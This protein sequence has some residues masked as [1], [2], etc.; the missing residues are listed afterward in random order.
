MFILGRY[1]LSWEQLFSIVDL[2]PNFLAFLYILGKDILHRFFFFNSD[3]F[4]LEYLLFEFL[5]R[6]LNLNYRLVILT[7]FNVFTLVSTREYFLLSLNFLNFTSSLDF[8]LDCL[9]TF[10][11][12]S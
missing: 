12:I 6:L 8:Q 9:L 1:L 2:Y 3:D 7:N 4:R 5:F 10:I 11:L